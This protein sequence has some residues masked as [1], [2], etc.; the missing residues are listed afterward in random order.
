MLLNPLLSILG[1]IAILLY[2]YVLA[3]WTVYRRVVECTRFEDANL[4]DLPEDIRAAIQP[5]IDE[6]D[7]LQ[8]QLVK[9]QFIYAG[10]VG[11]PPA[12]GLLFQGPNSLNYLCL[13][14]LQ[15]F[16]QMSR[17]M[18]VEFVSFLEDRKILFTTSAKNYRSFKPFPREIKQHLINYSISELWQSH[19][20]KLESLD[21]KPVYLSPEQFLSELLVYGRENIEFSV[22]HKRF[23]WVEHGKTYRYTLIT[24]IQLMLK[25]SIEFIFSKKTTQPQSDLAR[26]SQLEQEVKSF[27]EAQKPKPAMAKR[28]RGWLALASLVAFITVY[29]TR[30]DPKTLLFFVAALLLHEGGHLLAMIIFGYQEPIVFFIPFFGALATARKDHATLTEKFWISLAGP[31]P[32][33]MLG[34][35]IALASNWGQPPIEAIQNWNS[36]TNPWQGASLILIGLNLFNLL[37]IYPLDGGQ[38]SDLLV[39]SRNPYLGVIYKSIGILLLVLLGLFSP[40]MFIFAVLIA[41]SIPHSFRTARYFA[42]LRRELRNIP[43]DDDESS[44]RLIFSQL[45]S[46]SKL[47]F[48]QKN[49][50][51]AGI[52]ESRRADAA[53]W[54]SRLGLS[55]IYWVSL[56]VGIL[57]GIYSLFPDIKAI[58]SIPQNTISTV[59]MMSQGLEGIARDRI[60]TT[61]HAIQ[62]NPQDWDAYTK[63]GSVKLILNDVTGAIADANTVLNH[64]PNSIAA[65]Q[66]RSQAYQESGDLSKANADQ[67]KVIQLRWIPEFQKAHAELQKNPRNTKAYFR[68]GAAKQNLGDIS[69]A[70]QDYDKSLKLD[71]NNVEGLI[72]RAILFE[73]TQ[74]DQ[75][76]LKDLNQAIG[77]DPK[78]V[79]AYETR[80]DLY[81]RL[82]ESEKARADEAKAQE[83]LEKE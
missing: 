28:T 71:P 59:R 77:L 67:Q 76:A 13:S 53:P 27:L 19:Q 31:L 3:T 68:R 65:Y 11:K 22:E 15:P 62:Q 14:A 50:I 78:N 82:G 80:A 5:Y 39:F 23:F 54:S 43:F 52:F 61:T 29:A 55:I 72:Q 8:F 41:L 36:D 6:L 73:S 21:V 47:S 75:A 81:M 44:A 34:I 7:L 24:A 30:F 35:A 64:D 56:V 70:F 9:Y 25:V 49:M 51:A 60:E 18:V 32:G 12:W 2:P 66:L 16:H 26:S 46:A 20:A 69:G 10:E 48:H 79:M 4:E 40:L 38:I 63:R 42:Q 33:L 83:V 17:T 37:P 45:Q 57:G 74:N 1:L 58:A